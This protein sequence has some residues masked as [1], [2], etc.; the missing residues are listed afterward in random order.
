MP[1]IPKHYGREVKKNPI[2][3]LGFLLEFLL[4]IR[5]PIIDNN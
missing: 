1:T 2:I 5:L 3:F 4:E